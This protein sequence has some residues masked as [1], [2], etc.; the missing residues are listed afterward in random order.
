M[1][2]DDQIDNLNKAQLIFLESDEPKKDI[3]IYVNSQGGSV[4]AG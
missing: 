1:G 3:I 4:Y 2:I